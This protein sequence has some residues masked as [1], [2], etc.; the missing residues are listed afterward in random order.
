MI[1]VEFIGSFTSYEQ[2][3][4]RPLPEVAFIGR[5]NVGKSSLINYIVEKKNI[6][7]TSQTPGKTQHLNFFIYEDDWYLVDLPGYGYAKESKKKRKE[8]AKMIKT[9]L[10]SSKQLYCVFV[11]IDASI[12]AQ[13]LDIE[14]INWLGKVQIPFQIVYTKTDKSKKTQLSKNIEHIQNELLKTWE[15]LPRQFQ[16]SSLKKIGREELLENILEIVAK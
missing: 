13:K 3:P 9:Y 8:W 6:A 5:S 15:S 16:V 4:E 7:R 2:K 10:I 14:F 12:P 11:L 1:S